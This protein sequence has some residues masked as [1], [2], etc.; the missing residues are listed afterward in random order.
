MSLATPF[1]A[2]LIGN[3]VSHVWRGAGSAI[4]VEFG[5]LHGRRRLNGEAGEPEGDFTLMI[6]W[7]WRIERARSILG[8]S[9][10]SEQR[11]GKM[12]EKLIGETV[13]DVQCFGA[14]PEICV[15]IGN[16][17][18]VLSFMTESGQPQWA[19]LARD[20]SMGSLSVKGGRLFIGK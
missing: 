19:I 5:K 18:R 13:V 4:F 6:E 16:G 15:S 9:W 20:P 8:G 14:L 1:F 12:F 7:S 11:W 2:S 3:C 10:T 17:M